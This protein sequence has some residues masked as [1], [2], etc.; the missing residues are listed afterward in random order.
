[1]SR[2]VS[3]YLALRAAHR[4]LQTKRRERSEVIS[5][6]NPSNE[7]HTLLSAL[8]GSPPLNRKP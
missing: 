6:Q 5:P 1:M 8:H 4:F 3:K 2:I 7:K